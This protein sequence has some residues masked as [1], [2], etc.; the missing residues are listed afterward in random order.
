MVALLLASL[1]VAAPCG[2]RDV[3]RNAA[4]SAEVW[5]VTEAEA[6]AFENRRAVASMREPAKVKG[7]LRLRWARTLSYSAA[8][9]HQEVIVTDASK[10]IL[11]RGGVAAS[12]H[13]AATN[14][15]A[16]GTTWVDGVVDYS[17]PVTEGHSVHVVDTLLGWRCTWTMGASGRLKLQ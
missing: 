3:R 15:R 7:Y 17:W 13:D 16:A 5:A 12:E 9:K 8:A 6:Q 11:F 4:G 1:A 10:T 14:V 2:V